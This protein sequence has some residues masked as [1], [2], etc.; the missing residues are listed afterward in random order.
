MPHK[1]LHEQ[2]AKK[3]EK[4]QTMKKQIRCMSATILKNQQIQT[5]FVILVGLQK[6]DQCVPTFKCEKGRCRHEML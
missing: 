6:Y 2:E 4:H 3:D 5:R 1:G